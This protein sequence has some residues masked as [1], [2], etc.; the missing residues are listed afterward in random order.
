MKEKLPPSKPLLSPLGVKFLISSAASGE[1]PMKGFQSHRGSH[2]RCY[3]TYIWLWKWWEIFQ[4]AFHYWL[5]VSSQP[6]QA[7][8]RPSSPARPFQGEQA[9]IHG[10]PWP[11][12]PHSKGCLL[13]QMC[14]AQTQRPVWL[15]NAV[16]FPSFSSPINVMFLF[17]YV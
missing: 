11:T 14:K 17:T 12:R 16:E 9:P 7:S 13:S 1:G 15:G 3:M 4:V 6:L 5:L 2:W 10:L 8:T